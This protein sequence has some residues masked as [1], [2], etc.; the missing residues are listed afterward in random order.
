MSLDHKEK[1]MLQHTLDK[2]ISNVEIP[3]YWLD[4]ATEEQHIYNFAR[5]ADIKF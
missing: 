1:Q 2:D 3:Y 5:F 4:L